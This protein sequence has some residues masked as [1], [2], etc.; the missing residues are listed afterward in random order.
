MMDQILISH[1]EVPV[2]D[3]DLF[4]EQCSPEESLAKARLT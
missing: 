2:G 3:A 4:L 1:G